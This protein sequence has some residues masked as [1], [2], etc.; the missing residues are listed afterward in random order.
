MRKFLLTPLFLSASLFA[1]EMTQKTASSLNDELDLF[2]KPAA[3]STKAGQTNSVVMINPEARAQDLKQAYDLMRREKSTTNIAF[4]L[5]DGAIISRVIDL[6][7]MEKGSLILFKANTS[8]G[9][10]YTVVPVED[11]M[12][13]EQQ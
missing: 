8:Q 6:I 4:K 9:V 12:G 7:I 3:A 10:K 5:K 1:A 11:I 13:I 2:N